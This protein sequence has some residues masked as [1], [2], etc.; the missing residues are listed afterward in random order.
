M[1]VGRRGRLG[2][3]RN[4][5]CEAD[6]WVSLTSTPL[7]GG[8]IL[9]QGHRCRLEPARVCSRDGVS[10]DIGDPEAAVSPIQ[11]FI[12][13]AL[14][15]LLTWLVAA[16][17]ILASLRATNT[18]KAIATTIAALF[19]LNGYPILLFLGFRGSLPWDSSFNLLGFMPRLAVAPSYRT[20]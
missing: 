15:G 14:V 17:G 4:T 6:T 11:V 8:Q 18:S 13:V 12:S 9:R 3:E 1:A 20:G 5:R 16:V 10:V 19:L 7:T 2:I